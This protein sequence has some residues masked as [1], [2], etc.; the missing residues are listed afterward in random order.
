MS[1]EGWESAAAGAERK[2]ALIEKGGQEPFFA[3]KKGS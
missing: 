3:A 2:Q 1:D